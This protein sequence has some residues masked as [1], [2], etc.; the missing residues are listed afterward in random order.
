MCADRLELLCKLQAQEP[1]VILIRQE[2]LLAFQSSLFM[3]ASEARPKWDW[4]ALFVA[5]PWFDWS[6]RLISNL[7]GGELMELKMKVLGFFVVA[8]IFTCDARSR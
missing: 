7:N 1:Q 5:S 8:T 6:T 3:P 2:V 4:Y